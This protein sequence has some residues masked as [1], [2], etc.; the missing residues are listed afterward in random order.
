M[1]AGVGPVLF[2]VIQICLRLLQTL[3]PLAL[4]GCFLCMGDA[5]FNLALTIWIPH[6]ARQC[7]HA[8]VRQNITI[9]RVLT[10][11]N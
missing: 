8:V 6:L 9:E 3:E 11:D 5:R 10:G 4:Q 7:R 1:D 2:P